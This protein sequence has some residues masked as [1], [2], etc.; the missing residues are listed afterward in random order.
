MGKITFSWDDRKA[1]LNLRKH[2]VSFEDASTVFFDENAK[3]FFDPDHSADEDRF[4]MLGFDCRL[5][6]LVVSY[7]FDNQGR[8]IRIISARKATT[9]EK[10]EFARGKL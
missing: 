2:G 7:S 9:K 8:Q 6:L 3:E 5:R 4:L 1:A 10:G